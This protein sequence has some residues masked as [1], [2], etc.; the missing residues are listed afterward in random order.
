MKKMFIAC[1]IV[2]LTLMSFPAQSATLEEISIITALVLKLTEKDMTKVFSQDEVMEIAKKIRA[3][4]PPLVLDDASTLATVALH[5][6]QQYHI[7]QIS[8]E[9][10]D[11]IAKEIAESIDKRLTILINQVL[12]ELDNHSYLHS[13]EQGRR[14]KRETAGEYYGIGA[15][16]A[17]PEMLKR[18]II[19]D[20]ERADK[21]IKDFIDKDKLEIFAQISGNFEIKNDLLKK[22]DPDL[23]AVIDGI[24]LEASG[25]LVYEVFPKSPAA[26]AGLKKG[27][28]IVAVDNQPIEGQLLDEA[29]E[30]IKGPENTVV[31][32]TV[33]PAPV[34]V[35]VS[36][37]MIIEITRGKI[38]ELKTE[39]KML[40]TEIGYIKLREFI[41]QHTAE[42][43][44]DALVGLPGAEAI[45]LDLM[46]NSGGLLDEADKVLESLLPAGWIS[47]TVSNT[48]GQS[49]WYGTIE[50]GLQKFSGPLAVLVNEN[51]ASASEIVA[52]SIQE[53]ERG[54]IIG[55][56]TFGK[57]TMQSL[58]YFTD[59]PT[60][61][62]LRLTTGQWFLPRSNQNIDGIGITPDIVVE[63]DLQTDENEVVSRAI[64]ELNKL[65]PCE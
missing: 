17:Y 54:L 56:P 64:E 47:F 25:I 43:I 27:W 5:Y 33:R 53:H 51:S 48:A 45:I 28:Y 19:K 4:L 11:E 61:H 63:D 60:S 23:H 3:T 30:Q 2:M 46:D 14:L 24:R 55:T 7:K 50:P 18:K 26:K 62:V 65:L 37:P 6:I 12:A 38:E 52:G 40:T 21:L 44:N 57:G 10:K 22:L 16:L 8:P 15:Q 1:L 35:P 20:R 34:D 32:L 41:S 39:V 13:P 58:I 59:P 42:Q 31:H 36:T 49:L 9:K 29:V